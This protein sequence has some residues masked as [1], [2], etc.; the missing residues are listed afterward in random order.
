VH[1]LVVTAGC[2]RVHFGSAI[3]IDASPDA[4]VPD[5]LALH[6]DNG[7]TATPMTPCTL[8]FGERPTATIHGLTRDSW[9]ASEFPANNYGAS[10]LIHSDASPLHGALLRFEIAAIPPGSVVISASLS[11]YVYEVVGYE[12]TGGQVDA[13]PLLEDWTEGTGLEPGTPGIASYTERVAGVPWTG[14]GATAG[15]IDVGTV[16]FSFVTGIDALSPGAE[17]VVAIDTGVVQHWIDE[18]TANFGVKLDATSDGVG[19][20]S[21]NHP[22]AD[23]HPLLQIT[24]LPP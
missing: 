20:D 23:R 7:S 18:P 1:A 4:A 11:V 12:L 2:G 8:S 5:A 9:L 13:R 17:S 16:A 6:C 21:S 24:F 22:M 15:S 14:I 3:G 10:L 19:F